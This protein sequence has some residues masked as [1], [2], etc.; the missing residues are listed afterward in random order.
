MLDAVGV[1]HG[2]FQLLHNEH[3]KYILA[4]KKRCKHL[5][6]GIC[7]PDRSLV[8]YTEN[9]P[10]RSEDVSNP[11]SYYE[12]FQMIQGALLEKGISIYDFDIVP[13]P[14]NYPELIFSYTPQNAK[15][16]MTIY[17]KWG[18]EKREI[19]EKIGCTVEVM[20]KRDISQK[21]I[22][23]TDVRRCIKEG[24]AWRQFVPPSVYK[25]IK[26]HEL[27]KKIIGGE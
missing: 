27:D 8:K 7:N 11:F 13:F 18:E 21:I 20:W 3:M 26:V 22:S 12:R 15:Y 14:I 2:R 4:G 5:I 25:Y 1:V 10:H 6:I 9:S 17:D 19:L 24:K 16:Y 23:G